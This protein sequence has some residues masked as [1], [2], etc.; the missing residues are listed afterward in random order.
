[1]IFDFFPDDYELGRMRVG[2]ES[3]WGF[4]PDHKERIS[5]ARISN[6]IRDLRFGKLLQFTEKHSESIEL[7]RVERGMGNIMARLTVE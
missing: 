1:M 6:R 3:G 4:L 7:V 5:C 2:E